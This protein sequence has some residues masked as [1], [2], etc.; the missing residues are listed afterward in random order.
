MRQLLFKWPHLESDCGSK[1]L[2]PA[3]VA[4]AAFTDEPRSPRESSHCRNSFS[5]K[6]KKNWRDAISK[7]WFFCLC[8][9]SLLLSFATRNCF[10]KEIS[11]F[12]SSLHFPFSCA[13]RNIRRDF[14]QTNSCKFKCFACHDFFYA[15]MKPV[16]YCMFLPHEELSRRLDKCLQC[17]HTKKTQ[18]SLTVQ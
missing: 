8:H 12:I 13:E 1:F 5:E 7:I 11:L 9:L 2:P 18:N 17:V 14:D 10:V 3:A 16:G 15:A 4:A 6:K